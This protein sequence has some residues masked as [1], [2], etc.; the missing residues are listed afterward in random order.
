MVIDDTM[1][2]FGN[3][4]SYHNYFHLYAISEIITLSLLEIDFRQLTTVKQI[5][6][7]GL[8]LNNSC[9]LARIR[10]SG[11]AV[12]VQYTYFVHIQ[13]ESF[14]LYRGTF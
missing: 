1:I 3:F 11:V 10:I 14:F 6:C 8:P 9:T 13:I 7:A 4:H 5:N 2:A 12:E